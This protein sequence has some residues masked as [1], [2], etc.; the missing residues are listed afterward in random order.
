[1]N[2]LQKNIGVILIFILGICFWF[3]GNQ[4]LFGKNKQEISIHKED[5]FASPKIDE[6]KE[7]IKKEYYHFD[8]K[9]KFDIENAMI[10]S[11]VWSLWDRHSSYFSPKEAKDFTEVLRWDFEWIW[12]VIDE[13]MKWIII[14]KVFPLSPASK[15]WLQDGDILTRIGK[16][17]IV[18]LSVEQAVKKIRWPKWSQVEV[19]YLR[20]EKYIE[21][22]IFVTRDMI[23]I[24]STQEKMLSWSLG[25][26]EVAF[27]G[28]HTREEFQTSLQNLTA[29]WAKG[30][31]LDFRNNGWGYLESAV[32]VLSFLLP[33]KVKAVTTRENDP[34]KTE[35]L[36][37]KKTK[38]TNENIPLVMIVNSLSASATEI[39]AW[40]LQDYSR[41]IIVWEKSYG[42]WSV[43]S[44]FI[45]QDGSILKVTIGKWYTPNDRGIDGSGIT[46]DISIPLFDRD[47]TTRYDRQL[48]WAK[49]TLE[50]LI[51]TKN[52]DTTIET[53]KQQDFTK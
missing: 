44:P 33:D 4:S 19:T 31:I 11:I 36:L 37:T 46:S 32:D 40:A 48:E 10:Q 16:E 45:L 26:L 17:S 18:W 1:M 2:F 50:E 35:T 6:A 15:S 28:D 38:D 29:S 53:M 51:K 25:Y 42:K 14:R 52:Y 39:V 23:V 3:L 12:A 8:Q 27:F 47:F 49:K 41:A 24:P 13:H 43:Q 30:I 34:K 9:S 21:N 5:I 7:I 20:G 22:T